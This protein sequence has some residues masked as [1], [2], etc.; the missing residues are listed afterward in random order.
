MRTPPARTISACLIVKD[1]EAFLEGCLASLAGAVDEVVVVDT[2]SSDRTVEIAEAAGARVLHRPWDD[3]FSAARNASIEAATGDFVLVIDADE[4]LDEGSAAVLRRLV[5]AEAEDAP[6]RLY[7]PL[8]LNVDGAGQSLGADHMPRL[9][10]R[11]P[12]LRFTGRVHER[13]GDGVPGVGLAF[14][15][16][17]RIV[18]LGYDPGVKVD[19]DKARRNRALLEAELAERP[20]DPVLVYYLA[21]EDY[22]AGSD[23]AALTGFQRVIASGGPPNFVLN[24]YVFA[25]ECLR[26][27]GR[28]EEGM[29]LGLKG[30]RLAPDYGELWYVTGEAAFEAHK[31]V[32]AEKMFK[33]AQSRPKGIAGTAFH[34]PSVVAWRA[35]A[36][37]GRALVVQGHVEEGAEVLEAVR[38]RIPESD[39]QAIDLTL[40]EACFELAREDRAWELLEPHIDDAPEEALPLLLRF[41]ER[42]VE[43][44]PIETA[45]RFVSDAVVVHPVLGDL[46]VFVD[47]ALQVAAM[48]GEEDARFEL[49]QRCV[50]L[51]SPEP[52]HYVD[53]AQM[54]LD[55]GQPEAARAAIAAAQ[56]LVG[57]Q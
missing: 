41:A 10:R 12:E 40:A 56:R 14:E 55:R 6:P 3:D 49:L 23:L 37:R 31:T 21:K 27:L 36:G 57:A 54:L 50:Q 48:A 44:M 39:R 4:R 20:D 45:W 11:R 24:A 17:L 1:E 42:S 9:W 32:R 25:V 13:V 29:E 2:G 35:E 15:D 19:R 18:H 30:T 38:P 5:E 34:D 26:A 22:A 16:A 47:V 51:R 43:A 53:L 33:R 52:R 8:I 46:L 7:L 28:P